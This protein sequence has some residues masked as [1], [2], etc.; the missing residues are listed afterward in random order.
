MPG[1][2]ARTSRGEACLFMAAGPVNGMPEGEIRSPGN[3]G[4]AEN[5]T[6]RGGASFYGRRPCEWNAGRGDPF[7][8]QRWRRWRR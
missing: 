5:S 3:A 6:S 8:W 2:I 7:P 1:C 4:D